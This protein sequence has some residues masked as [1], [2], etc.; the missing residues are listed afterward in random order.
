[1]ANNW[2]VHGKKTVVYAWDATGT[3]RN[4]SGDMNNVKLSWTRANTDSTTFG[5]D[6]TQRVA[7]IYDAKLTGAAIFNAQD[8]SGIDAVLAGIMAASLNTLIQYLPAGSQSGSPLYSGCFLL[9]S[10]EITGDIKS[11]V[12]VNWSFSLASGSLTAASAV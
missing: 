4:V 7:G 6:S 10:Y 2:Q 11:T 1:M 12:A 5:Q 9:D 8:S 3:C